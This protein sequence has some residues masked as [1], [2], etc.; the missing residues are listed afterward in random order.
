MRCC[1]LFGGNAGPENKQARVASR[2]YAGVL[3][4]QKYYRPKDATLNWKVH[5]TGESD[6]SATVAALIASG[7]LDGAEPDRGALCTHQVCIPWR[8]MRLR[9]KFRW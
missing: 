3:M 8:R 6:D 1:C 2:F 4:A 9:A 7:K 5:N